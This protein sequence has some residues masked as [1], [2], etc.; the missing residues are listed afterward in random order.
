VGGEN[1]RRPRLF[2][3]HG[4]YITAYAFDGNLLRLKAS[5]QQ[6]G[7]KEIAHRALVAGDGLDIHELTGKGDLIHARQDTSV[8]LTPDVLRVLRG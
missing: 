7:V 3:E 2:G 4:K 8:R 6:F 5:P 1:D